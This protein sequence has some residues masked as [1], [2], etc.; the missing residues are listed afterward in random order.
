MKIL[1]TLAL[2]ILTINTFAQQN[3]FKINALG[4]LFEDY[5]GGYE[6]VFYDQI[7]VAVFAKSTNMSVPIMLAVKVGDSEN[8]NTKYDYNSKSIALELKLY[9]A[10][11]GDLHGFAGIYGRYKDENVSNLIFKDIFIGSKEVIY[12]YTY[13]GYALGLILGVKKVL[14]NGIF[15]ETSGGIGRFFGS[16]PIFSDADVAKSIEYYDD[17]YMTYDYFSYWDPRF[18]FSVGYSF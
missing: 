13:Q 3:Y 6:H 9:S 2:T 12:S 15:F 8:D 1:I 18:Q 16:K 7:G 14:Y 17:L 4:L 10:T 11:V 5:G